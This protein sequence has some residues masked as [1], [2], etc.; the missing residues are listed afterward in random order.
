ML[1]NGP[2]A[3]QALRHVYCHNQLNKNNNAIYISCI[4]HECFMHHD[5]DLIKYYL[6]A[7]KEM[8]ME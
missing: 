4:N 7:F 3:Y 1:H 8:Q 2:L 6:L 5:T